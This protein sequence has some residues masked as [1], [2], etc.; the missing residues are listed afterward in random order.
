[1]PKAVLRDNHLSRLLGGSFLSE[2]ED[3]EIFA[4]A[5]GFL[6]KP[7]DNGCPSYNC[8]EILSAERK[9]QIKNVRELQRLKLGANAKFAILKV[10]DVLTKIE[11]EINP[12]PPVLVLHDE[13]EACSEY[14]ADP[15]H[16]IMTNIPQKSGELSPQ[17]ELYGDLI[18]ECVTEFY[19]ARE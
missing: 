9:Q 10:D 13:L 1:M 16:C 2:D 18:A 3:G 6:S 12:D 19:P 5:T 7:K 4:Q 11:L 8:L 15:S 17:D 14:P